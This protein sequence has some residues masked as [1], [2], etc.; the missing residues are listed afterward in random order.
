MATTP[1][2]LPLTITK[3]IHFGPI[4]FNFKQP[5]GDPFDFTDGGTWKILAYAR[6]TKNAKDK[7][8]LAPVFSDAPNGEARI[9]FS[10]EQTLAQMGGTYAW[11]LILES[12]AGVR[13]GPYFEGPYHVREINTHV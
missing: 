13:I 12:P 3:G 7:I 11:D 4:I 9:E 6:R 2:N 1:A 5:N 8:D 10:D